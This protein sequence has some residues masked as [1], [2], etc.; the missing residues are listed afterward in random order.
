MFFF[1]DWQYLYSLEENKMEE[2][3]SKVLLSIIIGVIIILLL[4]FIAVLYLW[5]FPI[6]VTIK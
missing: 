1:Q 3:T 2:R 4:V 6:K 5:K